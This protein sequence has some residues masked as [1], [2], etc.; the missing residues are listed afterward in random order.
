MIKK[1]YI[2]LSFFFLHCTF[3]IA[4]EVSIQLGRNYITLNEQFTITI[5]VIGGKIESHTAFP[6]VPGFERSGEVENSSM[7]SV[8]GQALVVNRKTQLYI[9]TKA[10]VVKLKPFRIKVNGEYVES[11]GTTITVEEAP[12]P[13]LLDDLF[14][15]RIFVERPDRAFLSYVIDKQE[16]YLGE[17]FTLSLAFNIPENEQIM[18]DFLDLTNQLTK[19]IQQIKPM[20]SWEENMFSAQIPRQDVTINGERYSRYIIYRARYYPLTSD[21]IKFPAVDLDVT[22]YKL[23]K[24]KGFFGPGR[25]PIVKTFTTDSLTVKVKELP[26]HPLKEEVAVG[27]F[28]LKEQVSSK[29]V[30]TGESFTYNFNIVGQGNIAAIT[31]PIPPEKPALTVYEP[32]EA[33]NTRKTGSTVIGIKQFSYYVV[34]NQPGRH[35]LGEYFNWIYFNTRLE[36]YDTL[37]AKTIVTATGQLAKGDSLLPIDP[38]AFYDKL[39]AAS[40]NLRPLEE[41]SS[42]RG[43][44]NG[45]IFLMFAAVVVLLIR[46]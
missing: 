16:V 35:K 9:P 2:L 17:G 44:V 1:I 29:R 22:K 8:N 45:L 27:D 28:Q 21:D 13:S 38:S 19:I 41:E 34:P 6:D 5:S 18:F 15:R 10:G 4:Q 12:E 33:T 23:E 7:A 32:T 43:L 25:Q 3:A 31:A 20:N 14:G 42:L 37:R 46:K 40:N 26:P 36:K 11:D 39:G 30:A 24:N